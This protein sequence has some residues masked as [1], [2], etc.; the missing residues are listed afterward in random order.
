MHD[1]RPKASPL[2]TRT[3]LEKTAG[4][5]RNDPIRARRF[6]GIQFRAK[7]LRGHLRVEKVVGSGGPATTLGIRVRDQFETFDRREQMSRCGANPLGMDQVARVVVTRPTRQFPFG[8]PQSNLVQP[9]AYVSNLTG[10]NV[11]TT[12]KPLVG[13]P[14]GGATTR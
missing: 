8:R 11:P 5:S 13:F 6:E 3:K 10:E 9:L 4:I 2:G 12:G 14:Q 7:N 1:L